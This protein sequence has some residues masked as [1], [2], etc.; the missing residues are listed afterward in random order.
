M[1]SRSV[2]PS[3][4]DSREMSMTATSVSGCSIRK[5]IAEDGVVTWF[6]D[7]PSV[8]IASLCPMAKTVESSTSK[9]FSC[10]V[11]AVL[12]SFRSLLQGDFYLSDFLPFFPRKPEK[13]R[14]APCTLSQRKSCHL[15]CSGLR[16]A[17]TADGRKPTGAPAFGYS[18]ARDKNTMFVPVC[19]WRYCSAVRMN[20]PG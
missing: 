2:R 5:D 4:S 8:P 17:Q 12:L 19:Q 6:T 1:L 3:V 10:F 11:I 15:I 20:D 7:I 18:L 9:I 16:G 14:L 13:N